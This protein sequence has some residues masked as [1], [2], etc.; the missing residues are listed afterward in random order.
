MVLLGGMQTLAGPL[1]GAVALHLAARHASRAAPTTGARCWARMILLLVLLFP[2]GIVGFARAL[3]RRALA[4]DAERRSRSRRARRGGRMSLLAGRG[5]GKSFGGVKAVDGV[6]FDLA[7]GELLALIG[8]NGAGKS[9]TL[10]H[11]QRP[12]AR[13]RRLD[14][15]RR[16]ARSSACAPRAIWRLGVGRTFQIAATFASLTVRR[17]RADG[18]AVARR[19]A[20]FDSWRPR[21]VHYARR[22]DGAARRRSAW[23]AQA[24][25]P[26]SVLAYGDVKRVELA[27][28]L[29]NAPKLLLMDEPTAGMAPK[30]RNELMALTKQLVRERDIARAVHRAQHG[31][32]VRLRRPHDRA[33][34]RPADRRRQAPRRS[35]TTRSVQ[36]V[37]FGTGKTFE[38]APRRRR[39]GSVTS[40][41]MSAAP[42]SR[43]CRRRRPERV[44]RRAQILFDVDLEVGRGEVVALMGRNGA[45]KS[46]TL[47]AHHGAAAARARHACASRATT[48]RALPPYRIARLG[49]G[50]V[51]ED[52]RIF[53][54]LTV[55][56]NLEVGRQPPR[57]P[58][59][60]ARGRRSG[61]SR[62]SPTSARCAT[63][64]AAG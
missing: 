51:P 45:G 16:P 33:G 55:L 34:A 7:A 24:D 27:I 61:C 29:A 23:R 42:S 11:G 48:S 6:A 41:A 47:K 3:R 49:L 15:A 30:E 37:Y 63:G 46:T 20:A 39:H 53:T 14:R 60:R 62:C 57:W 12:A 59:A 22:G 28:A 43:C 2:Q 31:R 13:R 44:V 32:G 40:A 26:C 56:E 35:A 17:E 38:Q 19:P 36:E 8:P 18:A 50:F 54:D 10:Q 25:R 1:V 58:G 21:R 52:R 4:V 9:T 64:P 5:L